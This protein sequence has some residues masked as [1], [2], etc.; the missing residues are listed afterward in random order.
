MSIANSTLYFT[1]SGASKN[2]VCIEFGAVDQYG[3]GTCKFLSHGNMSASFRATEDS[4]IV[5]AGSIAFWTG[6]M[7]GS[8][9][10]GMAANVPLSFHPNPPYSY[11]L[12]TTPSSE[13]VVSDSEEY[14]AVKSM[15]DA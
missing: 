3:S 5:K 11:T 4:F 15:L 7:S 1:L 9:G 12:S 8:E 14:Q 2:F 13:Q 6:T 10:T